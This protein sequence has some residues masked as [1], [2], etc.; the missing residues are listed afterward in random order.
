MAE[1]LH[2][3][4]DDFFVVTDPADPIL[5]QAIS[6]PKQSIPIQSY[7][8][9]EIDELIQEHDTNNIEYHG[10]YYFVGFLNVERIP[11]A[12]YISLAIFTVSTVSMF[13]LAITKFYFKKYPQKATL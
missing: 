8:E 7:D 11:L 4:P 1:Q 10:N 3:K 9:T 12:I 5:I 6:N 2:A 13:I